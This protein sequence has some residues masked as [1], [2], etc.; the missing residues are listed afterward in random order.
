MTL[1]EAGVSLIDCDHRT[2]PPAD[3]GYPYVAIPQLKQGRLDLSDARRISREHF[4][5]GLARRTPSQTTSFFLAGA[6]RESRH[7]CHT[8]WSLRLDTPQTDGLLSG[9]APEQMELGLALE[10]VGG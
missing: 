10:K 8:A 5:N 3:N 2:P 4:L 9:L 7:S 1:R 6:I